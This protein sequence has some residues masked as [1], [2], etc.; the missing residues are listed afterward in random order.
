MCQVDVDAQFD[1]A[2]EQ[3]Q[4]VGGRTVMMGT[5]EVCFVLPFLHVCMLNCVSSAAGPSSP[6]LS[7]AHPAA[8]EKTEAV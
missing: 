3:Q 6:T 5:T 2:T 7:S 8:G 4:M 1:A